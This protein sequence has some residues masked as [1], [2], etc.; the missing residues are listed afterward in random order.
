[1]VGESAK[2]ERLRQLQADVDLQR[3]QFNK[4]SAKA[5]ELHQEANVAETGLTVLSAAVTPDK[6]AFPNKP[7]IAGGAIGLGLGMGVFVALLM[8]LFSRRVRS[9]SDLE[10]S[11]GTRVLAVVPQGPNPPKRPR[12]G[13]EPRLAGARRRRS[14]PKPTTAGA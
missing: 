11:T 7:L 6:P 1:M 12:S 13:Q 8:E 2:L 10:S 9:T 5:A 14:A 3:D 4:T